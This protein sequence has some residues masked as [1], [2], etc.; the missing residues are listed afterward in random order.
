MW[1]L[2]CNSVCEIMALNSMIVMFLFGSLNYINS[3]LHYFQVFENGKA[4]G[5]FTYYF[6]IR[7]ALRGIDSN[8]SREKLMQKVS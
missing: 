1:F 3:F 4:E 7:E 2:Y 5:A 6:N 8:N